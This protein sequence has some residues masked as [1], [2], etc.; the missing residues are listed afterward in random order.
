MAVE[1]SVELAIA[2]A[3]NGLEGTTAL[4]AFADKKDVFTV[5]I[6][7]H[8]RFPRGVINVRRPKCFRTQLDRPTTKQSNGTSSSPTS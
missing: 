6:T 4:T 7:V 2:S 1:R 3:L 8:F 5:L